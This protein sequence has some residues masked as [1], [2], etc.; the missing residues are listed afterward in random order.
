MPTAALDLKLKYRNWLLKSETKK[1]ET[2]IKTVIK[3]Y[4]IVKIEIEQVL[5]F[6]STG[7][8]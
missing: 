2:F 1:I 7:K 5:C 3:L 4:K 8:K 6:P